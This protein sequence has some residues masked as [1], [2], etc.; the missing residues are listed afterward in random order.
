[1]AYSL[2]GFVIVLPVWLIA[3]LLVTPS[4]TSASCAKQWSFRSIRVA[5]PSTFVSA[6][7]DQIKRLQIITTL[8]FVLISGAMAVKRALNINHI[9]FDD[10]PVSMDHLVGPVS[11]ALA[12]SIILA[13]VAYWMLGKIFRRLAVRGPA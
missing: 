3:L 11:G 4:P 1:M 5:F 10:L 6:T 8:T 7:P 13:P 2:V 12:P 9:P